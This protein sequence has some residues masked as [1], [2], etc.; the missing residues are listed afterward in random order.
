MI[1][2]R[3]WALRF[4]DIEWDWKSKQIRKQ[5]MEAGV[6]NC[7]LICSLPDATLL[8]SDQE[9]KKGIDKKEMKT[10]PRKSSLI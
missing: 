5:P 1:K 7:V 10:C 8:L 6:G 4:L 3:F 2:I 9:L